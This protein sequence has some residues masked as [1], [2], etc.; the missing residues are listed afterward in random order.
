MAMEA[1]DRPRKTPSQPRARATVDAIVLA[2]AHILKTEGAER[3]TT[4]RIAELAGVS[5]GSLYQ[6]FPNKHAI[7]AVLRERHSGWIESSVR[8]LAASPPEPPLRSLVRPAID[9][10]IAVHRV[11]PELHRHLASGD[12]AL[13][14]E[15]EGEYRAMLRGF[16]AENA[17]RLR[18]LDPDTVSYI[19]VRALEAVIH[20]TALDAPERLA[21][22]AF[23]EEVTE[24]LVRYIEA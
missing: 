6:Y 23:A 5:I 11:D 24:L 21:D 15:S 2:A 19:A 7:V 17:P 22:P 10:M 4:N 13:G 1:P 9:A 16:L 18:P 14:P 12:R 20:G 8:Q 3:L